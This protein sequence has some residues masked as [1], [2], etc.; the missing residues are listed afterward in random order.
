MSIVATSFGHL[1]TSE[2]GRPVHLDLMECC[3]Y[4]FTTGVEP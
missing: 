3:I 2:A 1:D 4:V